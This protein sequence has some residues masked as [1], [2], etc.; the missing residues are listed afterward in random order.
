MLEEFIEKICKKLKIEPVE[1]I[2][3][4]VSLSINEEI[5]VNIK[6]LKKGFF[7]TSIIKACPGE[8]REELFLKIMQEN[9][10]LQRG[11][12]SIIGLDKNEK[13]LTLSLNIPYEVNYKKFKESVEEFA[14]YLL[15]WR[16]EIVRICS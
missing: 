5:N 14:N 9:F 8:N 12:R 10:A 3:K 6:E 4:S 13:N 16:K 15:F 11:G 1:V 7:F 2:G